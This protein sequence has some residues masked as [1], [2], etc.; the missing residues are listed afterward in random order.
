VPRLRREP[1]LQ[2]LLDF[3][4]RDDVTPTYVLPAL[5]DHL[6]NVQPVLDFLE[7]AI[8]WEA[9]L[10]L[11]SHLLWSSHGAILRHPGPASTPR[12]LLPELG[13]EHGG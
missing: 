1:T 13:V 11:P 8:V 5:F 3:L 2:V 9:V 6:A 7:R 10:D 12:P 4:L